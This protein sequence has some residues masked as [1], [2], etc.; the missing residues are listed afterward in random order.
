[1]VHPGLQCHTFLGPW[2]GGRLFDTGQHFSAFFPS[3]S[4][5]GGLAS[6]FGLCFFGGEAGGGLF[7]RSGLNRST[8]PL[9]GGGWQR[10]GVGEK[11]RRRTWGLGVATTRRKTQ[12]HPE[13]RSGIFTKTYHMAIL[14]A[15][16]KR[17]HTARHMFQRISDE[18]GGHSGSR[19][20]GTSRP[21]L[22]IGPLVGTRPPRLGHTAG[23][24]EIPEIHF[25]SIRKLLKMFLHW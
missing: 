8:G 21:S 13:I 18:E 16:R 9:L 24:P 10:R 1:M 11:N 15:K 5:Q 19:R 7:F 22:G 2:G 17:P 3:G 4:L 23:K 14:W 12:I 20:G 6:I 25:S